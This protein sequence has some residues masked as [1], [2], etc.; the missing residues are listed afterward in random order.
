MARADVLEVTVKRD[1][2]EE[3]DVGSLL[4]GLIGTTDYHFLRLILFLKIDRLC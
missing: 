4:E 2:P 1:V 3:V